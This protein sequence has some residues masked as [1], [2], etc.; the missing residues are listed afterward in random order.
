MQRLPDSELDI[1]MC[2]WEAKGAVPRFYFDEKLRHKNLNANTVNTYLSRLESKGFVACEKRGR[3]NYYTPLVRRDAY[4]AFEG[5]TMLGKL[6]QN[7]LK[8]LVAA[9]ADA[10]A[11]KDAD[12]EELHTL[13][14]TLREGGGAR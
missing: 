1:M 13:L 6:Y 14:E 8:N 5:T 12:I 10:N 9:L 4:L 7:S 3:S 11:L 2:L